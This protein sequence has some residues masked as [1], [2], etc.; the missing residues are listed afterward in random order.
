MNEIINVSK[1][2]KLFFTTCKYNHIWVY[3]SLVMLDEKGNILLD[4]DEEDKQRIFMFDTGAQHTLL[5]KTRAEKLGYLYCEHKG[6]TRV[7]VG[8]SVLWCSKVEIPDITLTNNI[9]VRKPIVLVPDDYVYNKNILG[10]DILQLFNYYMDNK[11]K[12]IYFDKENV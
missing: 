4:I 9:I 7:S 12:N 5:S 2:N 3:L 1:K 8:G 10:Q 6:R 11:S